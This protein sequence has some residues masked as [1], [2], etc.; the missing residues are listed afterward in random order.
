MQT[1]SAG[2]V[3]VEDEADEVLYGGKA[4]WVPP[5]QDE[6]G[7][8][9]DRGQ[10]LDIEL[11]QRSRL[12]FRRYGLLRHQCNAV[13]QS[14]RSTHGLVAVELHRDP[15]EDSSLFE[16]RVHQGSEARRCLV[17]DEVEARE[18]FER[19]RVREARCQRRSGDRDHW[20]LE[21]RNRDELRVHHRR[22]VQSQISRA[23]KH[24]VE[25]ARGTTGPDADVHVRVSFPIVKNEAG[26]RE[27]ADGR[28]TGDRNLS[29]FGM[30]EGRHFLATAIDQRKQLARVREHD[31]AGG[32]EMQASATAL[33]ERDTELRLERGDLTRDGRLAQTEQVG[34]ACE[35]G[36]FDDPTEGKKLL[37]KHIIYSRCT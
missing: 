8:A 1:G 9:H 11:Q 34:G 6:A 26:K 10:V 30:G 23:I 27:E 37:Q 24:A 17:D 28:H 36:L 29:P 15:R 22:A 31:F 25:Q 20:V 4:P 5:S 33:D 13:A 7:R 35:A 32:G 3:A 19:N 16:R 21:E 2:L 14:Y 18:H 12:Q